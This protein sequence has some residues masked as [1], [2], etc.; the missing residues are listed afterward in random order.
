TATFFLL[1]KATNPSNR[2][3]EWDYIT[4]FCNQINKELEGITEDFI[5]KLSEQVKTKV[6]ELLYSWSVVLPDEAKIIEAYQ[7]LKKQDSFITNI[8]IDFYRNITYF[9][10]T[11]I[12]SPKHTNPVFDNEE[13]TK[14][15][16]KVKI[17]EVLQEAKRIIKNMDVAV[18]NS[19]T[20]L[21]EMRSH[22]KRDESTQEGKELLNVRHLTFRCG[23]DVVT[24][25]D[26]DDSALGDILHASD[27][28]SRVINSYKRIVEGQTI[29][30]DLPGSTASECT[31]DRTSPEIL[32]NLADLDSGTPSPLKNVLTSPQ[33]SDSLPAD[34]L[35]LTPL[36][37]AYSA[38]LNPVIST[39]SCKDFA[40]LNLDKA[41]SFNYGSNSELRAAEE[42]IHPALTA[43][44][45][46][47]GITPVPSALTSAKPQSFALDSPLFRSLSPTLPTSQSPS[48]S[49]ISLTSV[50]V[51]L[52]AI[53]PT[54]VLVRNVVLQAA[55]P[56]LEPL[57]APS[58]I[59]QIVLLD[60]PLKEKV[61]MRYKLT[62]ILGDRQV[63]ESEEIDKF[64]PVE[65]WGHL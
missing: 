27:D 48:G 26:D 37:G 25:T 33:H 38:P 4:R 54:P 49:D 58:S 35:T 22:F 14:N 39:Q 62:F 11:L 7:L 10:S 29:M 24:A 44:C 12:P 40:M 19:V 55:V 3:K 36:V 59:T 30:I 61:R 6:I 51:P 15:F 65:R 45:L 17:I 32:I 9:I 47:A 31:T 5:M 1:D 8:N 28:L 18:N 41:R 43:F 64:P 46:P 23:L 56:L 20:L 13:K 21:N 57:H 50:F 63:T 34:L 42:N 52:E 2:Q 60:N 16:L 53:K